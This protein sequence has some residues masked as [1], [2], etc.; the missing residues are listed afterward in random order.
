M[1][2]RKVLKKIKNFAMDFLFSEEWV[3]IDKPYGK[4][5]VV[6]RRRK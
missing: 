5:K 3:I 2:L 4:W 6:R 1:T